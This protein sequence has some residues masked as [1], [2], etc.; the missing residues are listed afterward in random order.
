[1]AAKWL[2]QADRATQLLFEV[3]G[4]AYQLLGSLDEFLALTREQQH[5]RISKLHK[6]LSDGRDLVHEMVESFYGSKDGGKHG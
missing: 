3:E 1:M 2:K 4:A 5:K 6:Q